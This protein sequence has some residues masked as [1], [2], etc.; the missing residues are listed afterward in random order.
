MS[1]FQRLAFSIIP[2]S[3]AVLVLLPLVGSS[4]E[5]EKLFSSYRSKKTIAHKLSPEL[6]FQIILHGFLH[7]ASMGFLM[8]VGILIVRMSNREECGKKL[9]I[10]YY[11]HVILQVAS[12]LL[13][14]AGAIMSMKNFEN[15]FNNTHQ[16]IGLVLYGIILVQPLIGFCRPQRGAR[17]RSVWY[18]AHWIL[19]TGVT[20][21]G[22]INVYTGLHV[23]QRK[24]SRSTWI[25][26]YLFSAEI[27]L[28][29]FIYLLQDRWEYM[30]KQGV[31]LGEEPIAP[32]DQ[33]NSPRQKQKE[34]TVPD[35]ERFLFN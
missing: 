12:V 16:R 11:C 34:L 5:P 2:A 9:K 25:W 8:P 13:A 31:M 7:W 20:I 29:A 17:G 32:T 18:F 33:K 10:L 22:I 6:S 15:S 14:T 3:F 30:K 24:T 23:Y 4:R 28:I 26:S 35:R 21:L 19:G 1:V 27:A